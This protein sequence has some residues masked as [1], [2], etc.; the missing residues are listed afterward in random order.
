MG[1]DDNTS[2]LSSAPQGTA[3]AKPSALKIGSGTSLQVP[4]RASAIK[5]CSKRS[6]RALVRAVRRQALRSP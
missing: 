6:M 3:P 1:P 2:E 4:T 5:R